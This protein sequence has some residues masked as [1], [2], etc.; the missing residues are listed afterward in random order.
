MYNVCSLEKLLPYCGQS[1]HE[2][3]SWEDSCAIHGRACLSS[4][5]R[6]HSVISEENGRL[7]SSL[8][9]ALYFD[10]KTRHLF[11]LKTDTEEAESVFP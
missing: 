6:E 11:R 1:A 9:N 3:T 2:V 4:G 7:T 10:T 8:G 5:Q